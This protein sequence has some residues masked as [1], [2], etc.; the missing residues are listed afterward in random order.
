MP[1]ITIDGRPLSVAEGT[2]V[3]KAAEAAG[4]PIPHL[5]Y[6]PAFAAEGSCRICLVEIEGLP[7]LELACATVVREGLKVQTGNPSVREARRA[8][9]EFLLADHPLDCPICDKAGECKLQDYFLEYGLTESAFR[10]DKERRAKKVRIGERLLLDRERCILCT[11]CVRFLRDI[12]KTRELGVFERGVHSEIGVYE[13]R[14]VATPYGGNLVDLCPVGAIT[15]TTFRFK[16]RTWFLS[17]R[18]SICPLCSRG[19]GIFIDYHPGFPRVAGSAKAYRIRPRLNPSV[20][21]PWICDLGRYN[22]LDHHLDRLRK[23]LWNRGDRE[24][25][26]SRDRVT[27]ILAEKVKELTARGRGD[28]IGLVLNTGLT[29]E[30]LR[31]IRDVFLGGTPSPRPWFADPPQGRDDGFLLRAE[32][33]ANRRGAEAL[34]FRIQAV[35]LDEIGGGLEVLFVFGP[36]LKEAGSA[37]TIE[38]ALAAVGTKVLMT[39][40]PSGLERL[41]DFV[42][43]AT[44]P[45]EKTGTFINADG[46]EQAFAQALPPCGE[47]WAEGDFVTALGREIGRV[48]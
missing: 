19:C 16:T 10:D 41:F 5:C 35:D 25:E 44:L 27:A 36:Y 26:M 1:N 9:L 39:A 15:D 4:I 22:Y 17:A 40:M 31:S 30:D 7:K 28:R 8:V 20:N 23:I 21:G 47:A 13:D 48:S 29:Q 43:P 11:R 2:T 45:S 42:L 46:L 12:T 24:M 3:L 18:L 37:E 32:R 33:T 34:G 6:H 14:Q 38:R